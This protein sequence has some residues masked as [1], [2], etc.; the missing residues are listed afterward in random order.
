MTSKPN[1]P[2]TTAE[3]TVDAVDERDVRALTETMFVD[4]EAPDFYRVRTQRGDEYVVD[5]REPACTCPDFQY[6]DVRCKH[7]RRVQFEAGEL[8][9]DTVAADVHTALDA[10]DDRL[11]ALAARRAEYVG[12]LST[13]DRFERR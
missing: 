4:R 6:R 9:P 13:I 12:L 3:S 11:A 7:V 8:D 1:V 10:L 5:T 2:N